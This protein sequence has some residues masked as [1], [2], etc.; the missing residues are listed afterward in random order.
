[1]AMRTAQSPIVGA[2]EGASMRF[3]AVPQ[4]LLVLVRVVYVKKPPGHGGAGPSRARMWSKS[5]QRRRLLGRASD[6]RLARASVAFRLDVGR[7]RSD[8][9]IVRLPYSEIR[10]WSRHCLRRRTMRMLSLA[11]LG[12]GDVRRA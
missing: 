7:T 12:S 1:M 9:R 6:W 2:M 8:G 4:S 3:L 10:P 11:T 5:D